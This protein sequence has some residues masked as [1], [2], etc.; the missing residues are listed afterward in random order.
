MTMTNLPSFF[1]SARIV[2]VVRKISPETLPDVVAA[3]V[4]GGLTAIEV[5]MESSGAAHS[6]A[7]LRATY[8]ARVAIGAGTIRTVAQLDEAVQAGADF[9]VCPHFNP[10]LMQRAS[11]LGCALVPGVLTPSEIGMALD[12]G[13]QVVKLFPAGRMGPEYIKDLL[14]P[15][16]DLQIMVTGGIGE[17]DAASYIRAGAIAVGMGSSLFPRADMI[18]GDFSAIAARTRRLL[19]QIDEVVTV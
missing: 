9:L 11:Q 17:A 19:A 2:A 7:A 12:A 4:Q 13:A 15:F 10:R 8:D 18:A 14:G 6:I 16:D 1:R 3:L 5:T